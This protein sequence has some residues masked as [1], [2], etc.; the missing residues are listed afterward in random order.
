MGVN[1]GIGVGVDVGN[2]V[3]VGVG[4]GVTD[5]AGVDVTVG[6]GARV[7]K[8][9]IVGSTAAFPVAVEGVEQAGAID[10]NAIEPKKVRASASP[11]RMSLPGHRQGPTPGVQQQS[12]TTNIHRHYPR[13]PVYFEVPPMKALS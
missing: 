7:T 9:E 4:S 6:V 13:A 12:N 10:K 5:G 8:A 3:E 11:A 1:V 2:G